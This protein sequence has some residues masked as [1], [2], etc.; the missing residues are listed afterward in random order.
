MELKVNG[1]D[2]FNQALVYYESNTGHQNYWNKADLKRSKYVE[3]LAMIKRH[4]N[5]NLM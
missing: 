4:F 2:L 3:S 5:R 1:F